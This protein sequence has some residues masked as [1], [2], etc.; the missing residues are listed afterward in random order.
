[1]NKLHTYFKKG[2]II[3]II[4]ILLI[5][6]SVFFIPKNSDNKICVIKQNN[7]I[8]KTI[9]LTDNTNDVVNIHSDYDTTIKVQNGEVFV[10]KST[11]PNQICVNSGK[12]S[13]NH[14]S[15]ACIPN[16][17]LIEIHS[18]GDEQEVDFIAQ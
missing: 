5:G 7:K 8:V 18:F 4:L 13:H 2:D 17:V 15:I 10:E 14:Q 16:K 11:C 6:I 1:M 3:I 12:I 9:V